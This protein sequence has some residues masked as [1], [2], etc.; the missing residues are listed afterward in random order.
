MWYAASLLFSGS[1]DF[2]SD[3][4]PLWE[5]SICLIEA[6]SEDAARAKADLLGR[7][8][9]HSHPIPGGTFTWTFHRTER[10][11]AIEGERLAH[12]TEVFSRFLRDSEVASLLTPFEDY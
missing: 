2:A 10:V 12:G 8:K 3:R 4:A 7:S 9:Q 1:H 11:F 5:D 6:Q